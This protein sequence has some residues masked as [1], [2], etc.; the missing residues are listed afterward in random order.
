MLTDVEFKT[1]CEKKIS[2]IQK[3]AYGKDIYIYGAGVGGKIFAEIMQQA[4]IKFN[5]F[6]DQDYKSICEV[7]GYPVLGLDEV[8]NKSSFIV[9]SLRG[10]NTDVIERIRRYGFT[11]NSIYVLSAGVNYNTE[12]IIYKG[13]V[14]GKYTYG[15][16]GLLEFYP[17]AS[18]IGRYCSI[19]STAKIWNNHSL[20]CIT[21][22]PFLDY[23]IYMT[24]EKYLDR[25]KIIAKYGLHRNNNQYENS[26][27]RNNKSVVIGNDVWIGANAIILPGITI[28]DG[29]VIAAGAVVTK[30]VEAYGIVAGNPAKMIRKR[31]DENTINELLEIKWWNWSES[32]IERNIELFFC[33]ENF[34]KYFQ[35]K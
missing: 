18:S 8:D 20:D 25:K 3:M 9:V 32:E 7:N 31:F 16:E 13:C 19:N 12:D 2:I 11:D 23:P 15:Y 24:W 28:G 33:P 30:D 4:E 17:I 27:I 35:R 10:Y 6:I 29:A 22:H 34:V 21:T 5:A 14:I 1:L 26:E